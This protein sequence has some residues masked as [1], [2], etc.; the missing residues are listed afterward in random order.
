[1]FWIQ[2]SMF[3]LFNLLIL[4]M[5]TTQIPARAIAFTATGQ[6][7]GGGE[8]DYTVWRL[9][10]DIEAENAESRNAGHNRAAGH[11][12]PEIPMGFPFPTICPDGSACAVRPAGKHHHRA[13]H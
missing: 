4:A 10:A 2:L 11:E 3:V 5:L 1:M 8:G 12:F 9:I 7:A 6:H 13:D